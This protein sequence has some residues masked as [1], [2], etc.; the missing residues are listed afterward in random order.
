MSIDERINSV[1]GLS[2][3]SK[4]NLAKTFKIN[5]PTKTDVK[6]K[7]EICDLF[8]FM[9]NLRMDFLISNFMSWFQD[10]QSKVKIE[11]KL[12]EDI[13]FLEE[14]SE[15]YLCVLPTLLKT[16]VE[17]IDIKY[18]EDDS[19]D[20]LKMANDL[21]N[22]IAKRQKK[23]KKIIKNKF[24]NFT[25]E[26]EIPDLDNLIS[27]KDLVANQ[28]VKRAE[29]LPS[30]LVAFYLTKESEL[31]SKILDVIMKLFNQRANFIENIRTLEILFNRTDTIL[32]KLLKKKIE[33]LR[34]LAERSEAILFINL[35]IKD[36]L[37][38]L[39]LSDMAWRVHY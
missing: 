29:I 11:K 21:G 23:K 24:H 35:F 32:Y 6:I 36:F 28:S 16:G 17:E 31:E 33:R 13:D 34:I 27:K 25:K 9:N 8:I 18:K 4:R 14:I 19:F 12:V 20:L 38:F 22:I 7:L 10:I 37:K 1:N 15:N 39:I 3:N 2:P 30:L 26:F 5:Q